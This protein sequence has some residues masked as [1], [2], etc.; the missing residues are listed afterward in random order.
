MVYTDKE[1]YTTYYCQEDSIDSI[2]FDGGEPQIWPAGDYWICPACLHRQI[3][4]EPDIKKLK[5]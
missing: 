1:P 2:T 3:H 5:R 4:W